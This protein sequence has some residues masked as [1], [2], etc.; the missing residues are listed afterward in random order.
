MDHL[1]AHRL[2]RT[3]TP[4]EL[5][6]LTPALRPKDAKTVRKFVNAELA[7]IRNE[8]LVARIRELLVEPYVVGL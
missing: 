5:R 2:R 8:L 7:R 3:T 6:Q 4:Q 1:I